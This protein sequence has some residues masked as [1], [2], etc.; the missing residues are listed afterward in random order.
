M[1]VHTVGGELEAHFHFF[2]MLPIIGLYLDWRPFA[3]SVGYVVVHRAGFALIFPEQVY[4]DAN[5][6]AAVLARTAIHAGFVVAEI[7]A[8]LASFRLA[9]AQAADIDRRAAELDRQN[10][11]LDERN[12]ELD[13]T[14]SRL[15]SVVAHSGE[16]AVD[17]QTE[18]AVVADTGSAVLAGVTGIEAA[19]ERSVIALM[20]ADQ[21]ALSIAE[22]AEAAAE[23]AALVVDRAAAASTASQD[24]RAAVAHAVDAI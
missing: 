17:V 20:D 21:V 14:V 7:V 4:P 24:G 22:Q 12:S 3:L 5:G 9:Q 19:A 16:L 11:A 6:T 23:E 2:V 1:T 8:L 15:D 13:A 18:A 10:L